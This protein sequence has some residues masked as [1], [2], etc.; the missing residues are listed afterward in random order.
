M[1]FTM[2]TAKMN[3]ILGKLKKGVGNSKILP[4]T[5]YLKFELNEGVLSITA[6]DSANFVEHIEQN[7]EGENGVAIV[8]A[9]KLINLVA[10]TT[11]PQ[12]SFELMETHFEV[13]GNGKY[14]VE[15]FETDEYPTYEF[16]TEIKGVTVKTALLKKMFA[17]N[18]SAIATDMLHPFFAGYNVGETAITSD[19]VKMCVNEVS[20]L[21][22]RALIPQKLADLLSVLNTEEVYIQK[23]GNKLLFTTEGLTIFGTELDGLEDYPDVGGVTGIQF[24]STVQVKRQ[25]LLDA[26]DRLSLFVDNTTNFGVDLT[27]TE[28]ALLVSDRKQKSTEK[29]EYVSKKQEEVDVV[30]SFNI[31]YLTDLISALSKEN[32]ELYY[33]QELPLKL[34]EENVTLILSAMTEE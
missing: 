33:S 31:N 19:G 2:N 34:K 11:K 5:E 10:K 6:T 22:E 8:Q 26:L 20:I 14:K 17:I 13:K 23:E 27:F 15:L 30:L 21:N 7:V 25:E 16:D 3:S 29:L 12:V 32:A 28:E 18:K 24:N 1:K 4:V 9:S